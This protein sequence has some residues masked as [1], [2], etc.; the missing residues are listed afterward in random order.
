MALCEAL[1]NAGRYPA[2]VVMFLYS[3]KASIHTTLNVYSHLFLGDEFYVH[4]M[5]HDGYTGELGA[6][7][8]AP[9]RCYYDHTY[10]SLARWY[11]W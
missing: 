10:D 9:R 5:I 8:C 3:S 7:N 1:F 4:T 11:R 6:A 2:R